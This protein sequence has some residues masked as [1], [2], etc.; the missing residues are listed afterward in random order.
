MD[1]DALH[2]TGAAFFIPLLCSGLVAVAEARRRRKSRRGRGE[3][4]GSAG[5]LR[6]EGA[7]G[8]G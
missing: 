4:K 5:E 2:G 8:E 3:S 1:V 7:G 6:E